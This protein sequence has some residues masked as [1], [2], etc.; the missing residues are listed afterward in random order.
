MAPFERA[1]AR[2][3]GLDVAAGGVGAGIH[4]LEK[5]IEQLP[6]MDGPLDTG[7]FGTYRKVLL[8]LAIFAL[9]DVFIF[10]WLGSRRI[11]VTPH[12]IRRESL[13]SK[14][15]STALKSRLTAGISC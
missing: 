9:V 8:G 1:H 4:V 12:E 13:L 2:V 5:L 15:G 3:D 6:V 14:Q 10:V 7:S 11:V